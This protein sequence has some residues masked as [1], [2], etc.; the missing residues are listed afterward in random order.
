MGRVAGKLWKRGGRKDGEGS[1]IRPERVEEEKR[2]KKGSE[3]ESDGYVTG[4]M[5]E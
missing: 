3:V 2:E 1:V 5:K 4:K